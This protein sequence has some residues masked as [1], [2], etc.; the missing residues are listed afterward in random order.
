[1][2]FNGASGHIP[3]WTEKNQS[4]AHGHGWKLE[5]IIFSFFLFE[6]TSGHEHEIPSL[7]KSLKSLGIT[8]YRINTVVL[9][10]TRVVCVLVPCHPCEFITQRICITSSI[11]YL[12]LKSLRPTIH[13]STNFESK[14]T[15]SIILLDFL[16]MNLQSTP[17]RISSYL[18]SKSS[19]VSRSTTPTDPVQH[20]QPQHQ[21]PMIPDRLAPPA[22]RHLIQSSGEPCKSHIIQSTASSVIARSGNLSYGGSSAGSLAGYPSTGVPGATVGPLTPDSVYR[23]AAYAVVAAAQ[24]YHLPVGV[25]SSSFCYPQLVSNYILLSFHSQIIF[26]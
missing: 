12:L 10:S 8:E 2:A 15:I 21:Q 9:Y 1:M 20:P 23:N 3:L 16:Q 11:Q 24:A 17:T 7:I 22:V 19:L 18:N 26:R 4:W 13:K 14:W 5:N 25:N 6:S